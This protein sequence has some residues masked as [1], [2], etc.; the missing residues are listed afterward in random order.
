MKYC[1]P[2]LLL[3]CSSLAQADTMRCGNK[4]V[5]EGDE[6]VL[7]EARCGKPAQISY[8]SM[9]KIPTFWHRGRL[10]QLSDQEVQVPV[11]TWVYNFGPRKFMR[12]LRFEDS[13][14]VEIKILDYGYI[15]P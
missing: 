2:L 14:L 3:L 15:D 8:S 5:Y 6:L 9:L 1:L 10:Y 11:E 13:V 12:K 7:V 4:L